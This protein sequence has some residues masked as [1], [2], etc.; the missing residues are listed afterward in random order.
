MMRR[1]EALLA[2]PSRVRQHAEAGDYE[3]VGTGL[4]CHIGGLGRRLI[5]VRWAIS[6]PSGARAANQCRAGSS[7]IVP[8][9]VQLRQQCLGLLLFCSL[10]F[11]S[12]RI[13]AR[14]RRC[15][16]TRRRRPP[17]LLQPH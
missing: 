15:L 9:S 16:Q 7:A 13:T 3:Q 14:Q 2:L 4:L 1:Y 10:A 6:Q 11:R 12:W 8:G 17:A 5:I